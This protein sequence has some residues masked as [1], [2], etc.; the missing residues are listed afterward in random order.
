MPA[1]PALHA[2]VIALE[3][4][5]TKAIPPHLRH[6]DPR[7][8]RRCTTETVRTGRGFP[9]PARSPMGLLDLLFR[10]PQRVHDPLAANTYDPQVVVRQT[11]G[12]YD[13]LYNQSYAE[14]CQR[15]GQV[16]CRTWLHD[17]MDDLGVAR[18]QHERLII[19]AKYRAGDRSFRDLPRS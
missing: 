3:T 6:D 16:A 8:R 17:Q 10:Q 7:P 2:R 12:V 4:A 19:L 1:S 18:A 9:R 5:V 11:D 14:R 15:D 13:L